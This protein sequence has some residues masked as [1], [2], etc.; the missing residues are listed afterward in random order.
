[1]FKQFPCVHLFIVKFITLVFIKDLSKQL[2]INSNIFD[3]AMNRN[4]SIMFEWA[5][6]D[7]SET[8]FSTRLTAWFPQF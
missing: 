5:C 2:L 3:V 4:I 6:M 8:L 7:D 1:M